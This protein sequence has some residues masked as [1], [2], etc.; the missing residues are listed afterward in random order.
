MYRRTDFLMCCALLPFCAASLFS[1]T[2]ASDSRVA[3]FRAET[4]LVV[5]DVVV[6]NGKGEPAPGLHREDFQV[7]EDGKPQNISVFEEHTGGAVTL[8]KL[9]PMPADVF[10]NYPLAKIPDSVNVLLLDWLN[11]QPQDQAYVRAQTIKYLKRITPGASLAVF[12][13]G[14]QLHMVEGFTT[15]PA[16]LL[17]ALDSKKAKPGSEPRRLLPTT[18]QA[19]SERDVINLMRMNMAAP[20]AIE[21]VTQ[22]MAGTGAFHT[23]E[24][25]KV[26]LRALQQLARFLSGIPGRKNVIWFSGSFPIS[27]FPGAGVPR[28][29]A[30]DLRQTA[31]LLTP[32]RVAIYPISA[33]GLTGNF[34]YEAE[35]SPT[36]QERVEN[37][38]EESV[39]HAE[40]QLAMEE[41]AKDTGGQTLYNT[42]GLSDAMAHAINSGS[43][44]YG[45][46]YSP[47]NQKMDGKY[48]AIQV[49]IPRG[50]YK[51]AYRRGY[52]ADESKAQPGVDRSTPSD[53]LI[54]L[55]EFGLPDSTQIVYKVRVQP[56]N[57][58]PTADAPHAG[59]NTELKSP[60][61]R[62]FVE[63]AISVND[64]ALRLTS[65]GVRH[66]NVEAML[67]AYDFD[68]KPL[69]FVVRTFGIE[70][71]PNGYA[72]AKTIGLQLHQEIDVPKGDFYLRTGIYDHGSARAGTLG[73]PLAT[74]TP[75]HDPAK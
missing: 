51:L 61:T 23:D 14:A 6:T 7:T 60:F 56:S 55:M 63:Y 40:A 24:R 45:L 4:R 29:Y 49:K 71:E 19:A 43:H 1:Q 3:T 22:E 10:T 33:E 58:Q 17:A 72:E 59:G 16:V 67:T 30:G 21:A 69:N 8:A 11:T 31:D 34:T 73:I 53:P 75:T 44:Y 52:Y 5:L 15:D 54:R 50:E 64:L 9:P 37:L 35:N 62:Y 32:S 20:A 47:T 74:S 2:A 12:T 65:D 46:A 66:G 28:Q 13:L 57:P 25:V 38:R 39:K 18:V 36:P 41:L 68:G 70:L 26:T 48:R 27:I 42:N